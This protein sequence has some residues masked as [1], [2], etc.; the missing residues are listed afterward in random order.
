MLRMVGSPGSLS[1]PELER[2]AL[3]RLGRLA[4][5]PID[6]RDLLDEAL[7]VAVLQVQDL[8]QR[9]VE[10]VCQEGYLLEEIIEGVAYDSPRPA[11]S[12]SNVSW[13]CGQVALTLVAPSLLMRW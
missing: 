7:P 12:I 11:G 3:A 1:A 4:G 5:L 10:V 9:P 6:L 2:Y 8:V 13:Q